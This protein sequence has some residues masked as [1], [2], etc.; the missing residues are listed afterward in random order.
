MRYH[1]IAIGGS[2]MHNIALALRENGHQVS[3]SDDEIYNPA[4]DRLASKGLLPAQQGWFPE[5]IHTGLDAVILGMHARADNPELLRALELGLPVFS[6]P[7][8]LYEHAKDKIRIV[9]AGSHGKT[10]TTSMILH[11]LKQAGKDFD[12]LVGAQLEGFETMTRLSEAPLMVL[13]GDEYF[14]S[15]LDPV[16][17]IYHYKPHLAILTGV[18]WDHINV[19]PTFEDYLGAFRHFLET[20]EPGGRVWYDVRDP[21]LRK[22]AAEAPSRIEC[23]PYEPLHA[24]LTGGQFRIFAKE[25]EATTSLIGQH[26]FANLRAA[27]L[28]CSSL[29]LS[30]EEMLAA[31]PHFKGASKRLQL[32][33]ERS[34]FNSYLDFAHAPSKVKATVEAVK[35][36]HPERRLVAI[37]ELHTFSSLNPLFLPEYAGALGSA[38]RAAVFFSPHTLEMKKL[39]PLEAA[40]VRESFQR[41]DLEVITEPDALG[42][43]AATQKGEGTVFLWMSSGNFGGLD[44]RLATK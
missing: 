20:V 13:E 38:D 9:V 31:I 15:A 41:P 5:K 6:Y 11:F 8:F 43:W 2:A 21:N 32:L 27:W 10:T 18:A 42:A 39:P 25:G 16:P 40:Q 24:E 36:R 7:A 35:G 19:F 44:I 23:I 29:G 17:K 34:G 4:R 12:Y 14:A 26:N 33:E 3:G 30:G 1:L 28:V 37:L 22:L